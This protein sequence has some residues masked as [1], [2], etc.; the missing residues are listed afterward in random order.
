MM[1]VRASL[2]RRLVAELR[3]KGMGEK[4]AH[5]AALRALDEPLPSGMPSFDEL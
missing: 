1:E 4:E 2:L 5:E 3:E